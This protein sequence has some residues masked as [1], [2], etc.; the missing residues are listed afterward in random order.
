VCADVRLGGCMD[1]LCFLF[2]S[3][4]CLAVLCHLNLFAFVITYFIY[5]FHRSLFVF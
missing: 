5:L 4:S 1:F 2:G 3:F